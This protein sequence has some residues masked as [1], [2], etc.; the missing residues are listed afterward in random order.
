MNQLFYSATD[1]GTY[2]IVF[3]V[4]SISKDAIQK[5]YLTQFGIP[6]DDVIV[7]GLHHSK[8]KKKTPAAEMKEFVKD[9]LVPVLEEIK[10]Q[11]LV[12]ADSEYFKI[13]T[14]LPSAEPN[15]GYVKDSVY[16]PWKVIYVPN[17]KSIFYD[18][19]A[20]R[21]KIAQGITALLND[22]TGGYKDPGKEIIKFAAYPKTL[23]DI[24]KWLDKLIEMDCDLASDIEA[25][26][27]KHH[28]AGIGTITFCWNQHEGIALP[29][30]YRAIPGATEAPFGENVFNASVRSL[31]R[32]FFERFKKR[33]I[34]HNIS[35][36]VYVLIYQLF[37]G[38][39]L[40]TEGLLEGMY[41][42]LSNW[43]DTKLI[44]YL[45]TNSCAGNKLGLKQQAQEYA[46]NYAKDDITDITLI[47]E[48]ELLQYNLVDGL[49][50]WYT[51]NKHWQTMIDDQQMD[52]YQNL[53]KPA[54]LD[55]IQMQLTGM[56]IDMPQVLHVEKTLELVLNNALDNIKNC[57]LI[58]KYEYTRLERLTEK[59]NKEWKKKKLTIQEMLT[60]SET[61]ASIRDGIVFNPNSGPQL[62]DLLFNE[63]ELPVI[64]LTDSK[65]PSVDRDSIEALVNH[66]RNQEEKDFLLAMLEYGSVNKI[67]TSFIPA[68]KAAVLGPDGHHYLFGNLNLGGTLSARLS[69]SDPNLQ[70]LPAN[71]SMKVSDSLL[72][73]LKSIG[74]DKFVKKGLLHLGSLIKTCFKAPEG[75]IFCG[76]DFS[77]LEDRISALTTKDP[78][79]LKVYM[80]HIVYKLTIDGIDYHIR[81]DDTILYDGKT[82]TGEQFYSQFS[83]N[84][85]Y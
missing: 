62:Q 3:L 76:L 11:Y 64:G 41:V 39:L 79:K 8:E 9:E 5:E 13:L 2:P 57:N 78:N 21:S 23:E 24:S 31:L 47:P 32:E 80:G 77:S 74:A 42:M 56:P 55:I 19:E 69:S 67:L 58:N 60:E 38:D 4:P 10:P 83:G 81:D 54:T 12:V 82:L 49:C 68:M 34:W 18:P 43:E 6:T 29:I 70:N 50:T 45:A 61:V 26:S 15:L 53:F 36:D 16:G 73:M 25:F 1:L 65:Q 48:D 30:D 7:L 52:I 37:M 44:T 75:W 72:T 20:I 59:K 71:V 22:I 46:G 14:K 28:N 35:Y 51:Y 85:S 84:P 66:A 33:I 27:L 63:L 40:D 17:Y